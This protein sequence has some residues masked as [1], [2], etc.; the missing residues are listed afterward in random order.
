MG[1]SNPRQGDKTD[2]QQY[3]NIPQEMKDRMPAEFTKQLKRPTRER[4]AD[5]SIHHAVFDLACSF[6]L[7][8]SMIF[9]APN[10]STSLVHFVKT[11]AL[12][13]QHPFHRYFP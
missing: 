8:Y 10:A 4:V 1:S 5:T 6:H 3:H 12:P 2:K 9:P 7:N 11:L 13:S